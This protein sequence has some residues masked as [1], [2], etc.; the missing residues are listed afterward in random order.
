MFGHVAEFSMRLTLTVIEHLVDQEFLRAKAYGFYLS[1]IIRDYF[2][3]SKQSNNGILLILFRLVR[4]RQG[5][6]SNLLSH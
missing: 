2:Y 4:K 3:L 1:L 6:D 5:T